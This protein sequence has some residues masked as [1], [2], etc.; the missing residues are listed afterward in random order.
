MVILYT[1]PSC[2]SCRK[3][4]AWLKEH[5]IDFVEREMLSKPL[6]AQEV[7][8][9]LRMTENGT[10]EIISFKSKAFRKLNIDWESI[11]LQ[12]LYK[13]IKDNPSMLRRPIIKDEKRLNV[14]FNEEEIRSFLPRKL[15]MVYSY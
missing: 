8:E 15:R 4:K 5:Q 6:S 9:I 2:T 11:Q 13:I 3:A 12:D 7:Q 10:D 1:T 14:G